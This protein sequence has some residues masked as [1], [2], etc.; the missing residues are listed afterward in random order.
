MKTRC[1]LSFPTDGINNT[2][3]DTLFSDNL[4]LPKKE[5]GSDKNQ[6]RFIT[7]DFYTR[8]DDTPTH[9]RLKNRRNRIYR[10][11]L[12]KVRFDSDNNR[13]IYQDET[14]TI[15][16]DMIT[17]RFG[18]KV[19]KALLVSG[20]RYG[21]CHSGSAYLAEIIPDSYVVT[22]YLLMGAERV[23]H[24]VVETL[25]DGIPYVF[26]CTRNLI[27]TKRDYDFITEF[28]EITRH[29]GGSATEDFDY[30]HQMDFSSSKPYVCFRDEMMKDLERNKS[31]F[32]KK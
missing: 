20:R 11:D 26:D 4:N 24:T 31:L 12:S 17:R 13:Y 6:I 3:Y 28:E 19:N 27:I 16:F 23:L 14:M 10:V 32:R 25:V 18:N 29:K 2:T 9:I 21:C 1:D 7:L 30:L 22:G 8:N 5:Q 15:P